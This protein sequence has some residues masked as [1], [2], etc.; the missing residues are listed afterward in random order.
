[1]INPRSLCSV[2]EFIH[3]VRTVSISGSGGHDYLH[4]EILNLICQSSAHLHNASRSSSSWSLSSGVMALP[5]ILESSA[6]L[7]IVP[8]PNRTVSFIGVCFLIFSAICVS[9]VVFLSLLT[10]CILRTV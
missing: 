7:S 1:M 9:Y 3:K 10:D 2:T 6:N 8:L 5:K 4:L